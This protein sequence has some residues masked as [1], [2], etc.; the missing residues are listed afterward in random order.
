MSEN[1][2]LEIKYIISAAKKPKNSVIKM[3][4]FISKGRF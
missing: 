2:V 3:V 4:L 1:N